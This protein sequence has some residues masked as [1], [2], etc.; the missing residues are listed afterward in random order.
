MKWILMVLRW[1]KLIDYIIS[2]HH[3][4][5]KKGMP[6]IFG[7]PAK[8]SFQTWREASLNCLG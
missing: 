4:Y 7:L 8:D 3:S 5:V 6:D 2:T 1:H